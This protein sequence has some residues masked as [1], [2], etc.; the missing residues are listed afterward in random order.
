[1]T[2]KGEPMP[3]KKTDPVVETEAPE[4]PQYEGERPQLDPDYRDA[5]QAYVEEHGSE[6]QPAEE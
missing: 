1:M 6:E 2:R 5:G 3:T 4:A